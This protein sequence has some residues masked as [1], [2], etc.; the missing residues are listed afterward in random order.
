MK[1]PEAPKGGQTYPPGL[2]TLKVVSQEDTEAKNGQF[3]VAV[4]TRIVKPKAF[5]NQPFPIRFCIGVTGDTA[6]KLGIAEEDLEAA[7]DE[8]WEKN[9]SARRY[10][11]Y[12][13]A[14]GVPDVQDTEEEGQN[15]IGSVFVVMNEPRDGYNDVK[16]FYSEGEAASVEAEAAAPARKAKTPDKGQNGLHRTGNVTSV[17][18]ASPRRPAPKAEPADESGEWDD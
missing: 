7:N 16:A 6:E 9:P 3:T 15:A 1:H 5:A 13:S 14:A 2:Y 4:D 18:T 8:T 17:R 11:S 10:G 12:L